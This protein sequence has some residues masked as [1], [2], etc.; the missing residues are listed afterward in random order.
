VLYFENRTGRADYD[1]LRKGLADMIVSDLAIWDGVTVVE[2]ERLEAVLAELKLQQTRAFDRA[3]RQKIGRL[4]GA[5]FVLVGTLNLAGP[6]LALDA[7]LVEVQSGAVRAAAR[8]SG[9]SDRVFDLE[10]ELVS[11]LS[12][13]ID[14][15][16]R[17]PARRRLVKVPDLKSLL[18]Y[19]KAIDLWD[20]GLLDEAAKAMRQVVSQSPT[21]LMARDRKERILKQL[22]AS[23]KRRT[24]IASNAVVGLGKLVDAGLRDEAR[25]DQLDLQGQQLF[26]GHRLLRTRVLGRLLRG[27]LSTHD[28]A[29]RLVLRGKEAEARKVMRAMA[30]NLR[31]LGAEVERFKK[32]AP[33]FT[34]VRLD[35]QAERL[36]QEGAFGRVSLLDDASRALGELVLLGRVRDGEPGYTVGPALGD[37]DPKEQKAAFEALDRLVTVALGRHAAAA[38]SMKPLFENQVSQALDLKANALLRLDRDEEAVAAYQRLLDAFPTSPRAKWLENRIKE[39]VGAS[40]DHEREMR[41]RWAKAL[42]S[43]EDMDIRTGTSTLH[44]ELRRFGL[45]GLGMHAAALQKACKVTEKNLHAF[46]YVYHGLA[47]AAA[48]HDD[49][50]ASRLW[51]RKYVETGGSVTDMRVYAKHR[52]WCPLGDVDKGIVHMSVRY[53]RN[54]SMDLDEHLVSI[55]SSDGKVLSLSGRQK[56]SGNQIGLQ[57]DATGPGRFK[58]RQLQWRKTGGATLAGPCEATLTKLS[59]MRGDFDEGTFSASLPTKD[60]NALRPTVEMTEG[61]FRLRRQ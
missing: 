7:Q 37:L 4:L 48:Q 35:P 12:S 26:L 40:H 18:G 31:R 59:T 6:T 49:C 2:R 53:D 57:L 44:R 38:S 20:K 16:V 34:E 17:D 13:A 22:E 41:E 58:C 21:F 24:E 23:G 11:R 28:N 33:P 55:L 61:K 15:K 3:G 50:A 30:E 8:A 27:S 29:L 32:R 25:F 14:L 42:Q 54:W 46:A 9:P 45:A 60:P 56:G 43:C 39:I 51:Y 36:A 1:V 19:S 52:P 47:D 5:R 10:Q